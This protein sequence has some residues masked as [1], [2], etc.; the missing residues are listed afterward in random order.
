AIVG[1]NGCGKS[2]ILDAVK[3]VLGEQSAKALRGDGMVDV[4]FNGTDDR[5]PLNLAEV[6]LTF[7]DCERDLGVDWNEVRVTRRL[8]RDGRSEYSLNNASCRLRDIQ[9]LFMDTGIGR[10]A[11]SIM[12]QGKIDQ[13]LSS[14]PEERRAIFEE[15]AGIT[16]YKTQKREALRKLEH[17]EANLIRGEDILREVKRQIASL[18]RQ[19][20]KA[21]RYRALQSDLQ[22]LDTH[23][24][25]RRFE[26]LDE[27]RR[28]A[29]AQIEQLAEAISNTTALIQ[30][31]ETDLVTKR[32]N[33]EEIELRASGARE[34]AQELRSQ[35]ANAVA[36]V[37]FN[38][39]RTLEAE[40][41]IH[42]HREEI[43]EAEHRIAE[44]RQD[45]EKL[46]AALRVEM[47]A[48]ES[49]ERELAVQAAAADQARKARAAAENAFDRLR[50]SLAAAEQ[51]IFRL[52]NELASFLTQKEGIDARL[53]A[54]E[55]EVINLEEG[56]QR[57]RERE[58]SITQ[59]C[60]E[61]K[62]L[63]RACTAA[64]L[65]AQ[66][67][68]SQLTVR[69]KGKEE[70][71]A[72]CR[73]E[74]QSAELR[75]EALEQ[76][77]REGAGLTD[78]AQAL[79]EAAAD[80]PALGQA[81]LGA[82]SNFIEVGPDHI[83]AVEA[84]LGEALNAIAARDRR[85]LAELISALPAVK[86]Q[87]ATLFLP[88]HFPM[89]EPAEVALNIP[90]V[91]AVAVNDLLSVGAPVE[92]H[93]KQLLRNTWL[94]P[95]L[96]DA[97]A[98]RERVVATFVSIDGDLVSAT[99]MIR[100]S[101][102]I[103]GEQSIL[104]RKVQITSLAGRAADLHNT[105]ENL[106]REHQSLASDLAASLEKVEKEKAQ[107]QEIR[108]EAGGLEGQL[109]E[110]R[111]ECGSLE[112]RLSAIRRE[113]EQNMDRQKGI[114]HR[115][116]SS[117]G[118][119][120][121]EEALVA[122]LG[123]EIANSTAAV[124]VA[125]AEQET[126]VNL[127]NDL[128]IKAAEA[129]QRVEGLRNQQAPLKA[130]INE[131]ETTI[132]NRRKEVGEYTQRIANHRQENLDLEKA[133]EQQRFELAEV[134]KRVAE[135]IS[136]REKASAEIAE[137][138]KVQ[139]ELRSRLDALR[140]EK[141]ECELELA[142]TKLHVSSL[143]DQVASRY[144]LEIHDFQN[145]TYSLL[146][147]L[148]A[149]RK[150]RDRRAKQATGDND[151]PESEGA[152][153]LIEDDIIGDVATGGFVTDHTPA[154]GKSET[155]AD[156]SKDPPIF[157][158][159]STIDW[160]E[161]EQLVVAMRQR[162]DGMGPVNLDAIEEFEELEERQAFL[163]QQ[164]TD[165]VNAKAELLEAIA[166]INK[167]TEDLFSETFQRLRENFQIMF[168]ELFGGGRADLA[169]MD[170]EDPL[171]CGIE[172]I[173]RPP[174]KQP[175]S[176]SLLSG[177]ERAM[178]ALALLFAIYMVK[179]SPFCVLDEMDAPLDDSNISRFIRILER[180]TAQSQFVVISH[181]K[182]TIARSDYLY[183]VTMEQKGISKLIGIR[184]TR[185]DNDDAMRDEPP[186]ISESVRA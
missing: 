103:S 81:A 144:A 22:I 153:Q 184:F 150:Q 91:N 4:I 177:G 160:G 88:E 78:S 87:G 170:S 17:T 6:S 129:K 128:R 121:Q 72:G 73:R 95:T 152:S 161:V 143:R 39:E 111:R 70:E 106:E 79:L 100:T 12:E 146:K 65:A 80:S 30:A 32:L 120:Q 27:E 23:L 7:A 42:R 132:A 136:E 156:H 163:E 141:S 64:L 13:V 92:G 52:R 98:C 174:G 53:A 26:S 29:E 169:L 14:R 171:E 157:Q 5:R 96:A 172:V 54:L 114:L 61:R 49:V 89:Q 118:M 105:L 113:R 10:S 48:V 93:V 33:L 186:G 135:I 159:N 116:E 16:K 38:H 8:Y 68:A 181:N 112:Q 84:A 102:A 110:V 66:E 166:R 119:I 182:R 43:S 104:Q 85:A 183:G 145:D 74:L 62:E 122:S 21:R 124:E 1:P 77:N 44:R 63:I 178:T 155:T 57:S 125:R 15:A 19:A 71:I 47:E 20:G 137:V 90:G 86:A 173:A 3:W 117:A 165:L 35:M 75:R 24:S 142:R 36:R 60:A 126:S 9:N 180:F 58:Q 179:P 162:L 101:R 175:Q 131:L 41:L 69:L 97:I 138:E 40:A 140:G 67:E 148:E 151:L 168:R 147:T 94:V 130:R 83:L 51:K 99:G 176:I 18:Q 2:N 109:G 154:V 34:R 107:L 37:G 11:Y 25:K 45:L 108:L 82:L 56:L 127:L 164:H 167:T 133:I 115:H 185:A 76:L 134:D 50:S 139:R 149:V 55:H 123:S 46:E 28:S 59:A 158:E 31:Q